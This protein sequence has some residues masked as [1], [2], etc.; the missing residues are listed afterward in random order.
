MDWVRLPLIIIW[1]AIR[2]E[3]VIERLAFVVAR[4]RPVDQLVVIFSL[5][6]DNRNYFRL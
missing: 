3:I 2:I 5:L 1:I 4:R 6:V